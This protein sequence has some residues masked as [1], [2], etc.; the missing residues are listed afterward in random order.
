LWSPTHRTSPLEPPLQAAEH[1]HGDALRVLH[2]FGCSLSAADRRGTSP[3]FA[4]RF[5]RNEGAS[6][7]RE[8]NERQEKSTPPYAQKELAV[9]PVCAQAAENGNV[10]ALRVLCELGADV[11]AVDCEGRTPGFVVCALASLHQTS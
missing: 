6:S 11:N 3:T 1:G 9:L 5:L 2:A 10:A 8:K 4:V 7:P